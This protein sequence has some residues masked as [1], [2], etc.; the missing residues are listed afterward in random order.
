MKTALHDVPRV[1]TLWQ[2]SYCARCGAAFDDKGPCTPD[3][4]EVER[5]MN[6]F[7]P[8]SGIHDA[9]CAYLCRTPGCTTN[10]ACAVCDAARRRR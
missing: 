9:T 10:H 3:G 4:R 2:I 6:P 1:G 8:P 7:V 5:R